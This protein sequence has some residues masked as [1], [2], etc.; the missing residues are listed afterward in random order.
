[1]TPP[2]PV[3]GAYPLPAVISPLTNVSRGWEAGD[4]DG[5]GFADIVLTPSYFNWKPRLPLQI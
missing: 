4:V 3:A 5:D 2:S 1:M